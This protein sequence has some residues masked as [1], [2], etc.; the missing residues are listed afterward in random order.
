MRNIVSRSY[1]PEWNYE[2]PRRVRWKLGDTVRIRVTDN[3]YWS[4]QVADFAS[5]DGD[6][7]AMRML[8]G[9]AHSGNNMLTF[10]S[11]F[12]MPVMPKVE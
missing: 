12:R 2:F 1:S 7:L 5:A 8:S 11:D 4:R 3:Y 10:E 9:E 6:P